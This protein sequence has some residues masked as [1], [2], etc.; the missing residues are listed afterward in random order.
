MNR[1]LNAGSYLAMLLL[2]IYLLGCGGSSN[3]VAGIDGSGSRV[4]SASGTVNGFGSVIVNGV[5]YHSEKTKFLV[6]GVIASEDSLRTGYQVHV[7]GTLNDDGTGTADT[8]EFNPNLIGAITSIDLQNDQLVLLEQTVQITNT[9]L[10]DAAI[11]ANDLSG[12]SIGTTILV[13][14]QLN[15]EGLIAA[16]RIELAQQTTYQVTGVIS[17]LNVANATFTLNNLTI[18]YSAAALNNIPSNQ[19]QNGL[20][21]N[22]AGTLDNNIFKAKTISFK[23]INFS[24]DVKTAEVEGFITRFAS[25]TDFDVAGIVCS[26]TSATTYENGNSTTLALGSP[27]KVNG[28]VDSNGVLVAQKI[29]FRQKAIN[30][31]AGQ[32]ANRSTAIAGAIAT[33][34]FQISG[35]TIQTNNSTAYEDGSN[36]NLR[37]FNFSDI[38][39]G[40]FLKVSGYTSQNTFI[41]TKIERRI[42]Q[43]NTELKYEGLI[44]QVNIDANSVVVYGQTV[45]INTQ[46]EIRGELGVSLT[47]AQFLA[48]AI[49]LQVRVRGTTQNGVFTATQIEIRPENNDFFHHPPGPGGTDF[50][51]GGGNGGGGG[52]GGEE[53][54][55]KDGG[56]H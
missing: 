3:N 13:S 39:N 7:T 9:T 34:S 51:N 31:I 47:A 16:T 15:D 29:E 25:T 45:Y 46:T 48:Q 32:V 19:L 21:V 33:G 17:N 53:G 11:N 41:A 30:E 26:T 2:S 1:F 56:F 27:L 37:R 35:T 8:I 28:N 38:H 12:L 55:G 18:N 54:G 42:L 4:T 20:T 10:F 24:A 50:D 14:G 36:D 43:T 22:V 5:R 40:D 44:T 23:N 52:A 6:N 49:N